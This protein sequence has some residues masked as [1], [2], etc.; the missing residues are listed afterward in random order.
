ME[1]GTFDPS[2]GKWTDGQQA[3]DLGISY[4]YGENAD[5]LNPFNRLAQLNRMQGISRGNQLNSAAESGNRASGGYQARRANLLWEQ[6]AQQRG[7]SDEYLGGLKSIRNAGLDAQDNYDMTNIGLWDDALARK[8][9]ADLNDPG[10]PE[11]PKAA[12]P[13]APV[14]PWAKA[15]KMYSSGTWLDEPSQSTRRY[16]D[17]N[18]VVWVVQPSGRRDKVKINAKA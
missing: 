16:R 14:S 5:M 4:G 6:K 2:T 15:E 8:L 17:K 7:L 13:K 3:I 18:G 1:L 11:V 9:Q 10:A 12:D